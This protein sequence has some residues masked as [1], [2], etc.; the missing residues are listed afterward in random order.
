MARDLGPFLD[1]CAKERDE[2]LEAIDLIDRGMI[3]LFSGPAHDAAA[4]V[5]GKH[6]AHLADV[7]ERMTGILKAEG[8][9]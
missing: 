2:A 3:K 1:W 8:R 4:D 7:V 5:T 6:R 9:S